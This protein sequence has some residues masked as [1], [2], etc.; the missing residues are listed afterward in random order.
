MNPAANDPPSDAPFEDVPDDSEADEAEDSHEAAPAVETVESLR[1]ERDRLAA[2]V[3]SLERDRR[4]LEKRA[5]DLGEQTRQYAAAY[6][7]A[8]TEFAAAKDRLAR[9]QDRALRR[10]LVKAVTG[11]LGVLD[12][13]DKSLTS[14]KDGAA[15][16]QGFVDGVGMIRVQFDQALAA[17]GLRRFDG[18]GEA[19][20][21]QRHQAVTTMT[22]L[23]PAQDGAVIHSISAGALLGDEVVRP[24]HVVVGKCLQVGS[25]AVN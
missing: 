11:L 17:M 15:V 20:D 23:D 8:R 12:N 14:V 9:E 18:L 24:A 2:R 1:A 22:V 19:F 16:G 10:E 6:D 25:D 21:P 7:K 5:G 3:D 13:L 4:D